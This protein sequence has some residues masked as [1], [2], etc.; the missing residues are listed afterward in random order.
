MF[1]MRNSFVK[2]IT[3]HSKAIHHMAIFSL[4]S[5]RNL[6]RAKEALLMQE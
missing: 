1:G 6:S 2:I 3:D 5:G 4:G